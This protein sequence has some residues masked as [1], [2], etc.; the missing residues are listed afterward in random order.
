MLIGSVRARL[1]SRLE[2]HKDQSNSY[3]D[4]SGLIERTAAFWCQET[5]T[6]RAQGEQLAAHKWEW[7]SPF[8]K[9]DRLSL[10]TGQWARFTAGCPHSEHCTWPL[11]PTVAMWL[12]FALPFPEC[13]PGSVNMCMIFA[14]LWT[15][16]CKHVNCTRQSWFSSIPVVVH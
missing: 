15:F 12:N 11:G 13:V 8:I 2:S 1:Y 6:S 9:V 3:T 7:K 10:N 4:W 14:D 16:Q 5:K